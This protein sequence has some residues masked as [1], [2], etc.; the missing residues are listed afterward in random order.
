MPTLRT[1]A[2][3]IADGLPKGDPIR[4]KILAALKATQRRVSFI[5]VA[6]APK[7]PKEIDRIVRDAVEEAGEEVS[8]EYESYTSNIIEP[9]GRGFRFG[10]GSDGGYGAESYTNLSYISGG[11]FWPSNNKLEKALR[12]AEERSY[13]YAIDEWKRANA[14]FIAENGLTDDQINYNDLYELDF[15]DEAESLSEYERDAQGGEDVGFRLGAF[16]Y[17]PDN[18]L[19]GRQGEHNMYVFALADF[20]GHFLPGGS[21]DL[22]ETTFAFDGPRDLERKLDKALK[23]AVEACK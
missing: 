20:D 4:R 17:G 21:M 23:A 19:E 15:G 10:S 1:A 18:R 5:Q 11:G 9:G 16:Y 12:D 3:E 13:D 14:E 7:L 2:L 6:G 8:D 22:F